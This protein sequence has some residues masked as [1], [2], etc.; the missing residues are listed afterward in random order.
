MGKVRVYELARE[1]GVES[2]E[3]LK[4]LNEMGEFV[5]SASST[6]EPPQARRVAARFTTP[7]P[8][9]TGGVSRGAFEASV[10]PRVQASPNPPPHGNTTSTVPR[11][12]SSQQVADCSS[13]RTC[14][15]TLTRTATAEL[16][17]L[18]ERCATLILSEGNQVVVPT[19]VVDELKNQSQIDPTGLSEDRAAAIKKAGNALRLP[20]CR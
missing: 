12:S 6:I 10:V 5:R 1:L 8:D 15:W 9:T 4:V 2:R 20:R 18:F 19:K 13:T 11:R 7:P 14:S 3:V 16:K 17:R